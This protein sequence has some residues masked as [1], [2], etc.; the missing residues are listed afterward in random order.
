MINISREC[1]FDDYLLNTELTTAS[2]R[3]HEPVKRELVM[4]NDEPWEGSDCGYYSFFYD[5]EYNGGVYRMY[6]L[7]RRSTLSDDPNVDKSVVVCYAESKDGITWYKPSLGLFD[8]HGST[9]NNIVMD[10]T[11]HDD[12]DNFMVF[13]DD[14]P[15]CPADEKYKGIA[16]Y[17]DAPNR[18]FRLYSFFSPDGIHFRMGHM[19]TNKGYFDTLNVI[20]WDKAAK[21][22][23]GFVRGVHSMG[24][25]PMAADGGMENWDKVKGIILEKDGKAGTR[26]PVI[27][28]VLYIESED[29][30]TWTDPIWLKY[31]DGEEIQM[32]TNCVSQYFRAPQ[33]YIGFPTRYIERTEWTGNYE[34][35]KGVERRLARMKG[36]RRAGLS[37]TDCAFMTSRDGVHF[38]RFPNAFMRPGAEN[39]TNWLYGD[40]YPARGFAVTKSAYKGADD[41][42][43]MFMHERTADESCEV[44]RYT[45]RM[46]GFASLHTD[47]VETAVTKQFTY[48]GENMYINFST[49]ARGYIYFTLIDEDGNRY[50]SCETFG[51]AVERKVVF[52]DADAVQKLSGKTVTMEI[53]MYDA[54]I[55]S[56]RFGK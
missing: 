48:D 37:I 35:I 31:D 42:L 54:D 6:Y 12:L 9:D 53:E 47:K 8:W 38:H 41:E 1:F 4:R 51:N 43:S 10:K 21:K 45:I 5:D 40:C 55:Y 29:F 24:T 26:T 30:K 17:D 20:M 34:Q 46:D 52:D 16:A 27:R 50:P 36:L 44:Y 23:R 56:V 13:R 14:N 19:L 22:Y 11:I 28:D 7:G 33:I 15:D 39:G 18:I 49:S 3:L 32:Y 2:L 25:D